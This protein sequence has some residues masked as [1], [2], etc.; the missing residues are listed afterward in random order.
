MGD[1]Q[2]LSWDYV[3]RLVREATVS[4]KC[5]HKNIYADIYIYA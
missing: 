4:I 5:S 2:Q 3:T 1:I